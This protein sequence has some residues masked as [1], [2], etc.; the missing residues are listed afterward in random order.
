MGDGKGG[1]GEDDICTVGDRLIP[2]R[3]VRF[4]YEI[5]SRISM[6][7]LNIL[8]A[9]RLMKERIHPRTCD[10]AI[11]WSSIL[12]LKIIIYSS[13][14]SANA[15]LFPIHLNQHPWPCRL[16]SLFVIS[17]LDKSRKP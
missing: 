14:P 4:L 17:L 7:F 13:F 2:L 6:K 11:K 3:E 12:V 5:S 15:L 1:E 9:S 10:Q 16:L 8:N